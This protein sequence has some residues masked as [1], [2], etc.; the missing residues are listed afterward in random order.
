[1]QVSLFTDVLQNNYPNLSA[2]KIASIIS[3]RDDITSIAQFG[4]VANGG[5][6][7][8]FIIDERSNPLQISNAGLICRAAG[9][10][11]YNPMKWEGAFNLKAGLDNLISH[12]SHSQQH[13][14][15]GMLLTDIWRPVELYQYA[16]EIEKYELMG[17]NTIALLFSGKSITPIGW[18]WR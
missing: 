12:Y 1:M 10:S 17:I 2:E 6:A 3:I 14:S 13:I 7:N 16:K 11:R 8:W 9:K 18:P 4:R 15:L 5:M